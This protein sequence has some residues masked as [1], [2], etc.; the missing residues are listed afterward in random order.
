MSETAEC[1][2]CGTPVQTRQYDYD[3]RTRIICPNCGGAFEYLSGFGTFSMPGEGRRRG[4]SRDYSEGYEAHT[5][6]WEED[7]SGYQDGTTWTIDPPRRQ[8]D[9]CES[10]CKVCCCCIILNF[11]IGFLL[12]GIFGGWWLW[13]FWF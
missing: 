1:P 11:I 12:F 9:G 2:Y 3:T 4:R 5:P 7:R 13:W 6:S 8:D 10:C